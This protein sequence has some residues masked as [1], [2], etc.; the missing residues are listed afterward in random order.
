MRALAIA[1]LLFASCERK[2]EYVYVESFMKT[3]KSGTTPR[4]GRPVTFNA[5]SDSAAYLNAYLQ[6]ALAKRF[7]KE[8][9]QK[10]GTLSGKPI[11][12]KV[13]ND[14]AKDITEKV[15]FM[16]KDSLK[17]EIQTRVDNSEQIGPID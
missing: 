10:S 11:S 4:E 1:I 12:F 8:E 6:F 13:L 14:D 7:Y 15:S 16:N 2:R 5:E 3:D 9:N 17:R